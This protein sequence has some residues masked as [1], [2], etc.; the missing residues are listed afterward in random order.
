M[1]LSA[2]RRR[3]TNL[4]E[5]NRTEQT[6]KPVELRENLKVAQQLAKRIQ[7][8]DRDNSE[9][10]SNPNNVKPALKSDAIESVKRI[11]ARPKSTAIDAVSTEPLSDAI[12][13]EEVKVKGR[14]ER[15]NLKV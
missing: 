3:F 11:D 2:L 5:A 14:G 12:V 9:Q 7:N 15:V 10:D 6:K 8:R 1:E 4:V 13:A